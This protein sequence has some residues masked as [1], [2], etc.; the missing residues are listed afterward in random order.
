MAQQ[1]ASVSMF[2]RFESLSLGV[3]EC[4]SV[5]VAIEWLLPAP[6]VGVV[7]FAL[8]L[9]LFHL[10]LSLPLLLLFSAAQ[11]FNNNF[12]VYFQDDLPGQALLD[13]V[14]ARLNLIETSYFGIRYIDDENQTVSGGWAW[15]GTWDVILPDIAAACHIRAA[16]WANILVFEIH[17]RFH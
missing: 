11:P 13:V 17:F 8:C 15:A 10:P 1:F 6:F 7:F 9:S 4:S 3:F 14:F 5:C 12:L 2:H 16:C